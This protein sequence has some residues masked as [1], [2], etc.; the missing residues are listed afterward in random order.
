MIRRPP[1]SPLFPYT[2][3]FRSQGLDDIDLAGEGIR[4]AAHGDLRVLWPEAENK[5]ARRPVA[6]RDAALS[7]M[8]TTVGRGPV[9]QIHRWGAAE[10]GHEEIGGPGVDLGRRREQLEAT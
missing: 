10:A 8:K 5:L 7:T 1:C 3:L 9:D 4:S 2:T 6:N